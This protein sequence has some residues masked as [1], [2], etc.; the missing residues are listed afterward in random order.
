MKNKL[1][2]LVKYSL[3]KKI[4]S[5][6]FLFI[7]LF[8]MI[9][10]ASLLNIDTIISAFGG[11]FDEPTK[12]KVIDKTGYT[13]P[14]LEQS[15]NTML[16]YIPDG[17]KVSLD[18][19][20]VSEAEAKKEIK[21]NKQVLIVIQEDKENTVNA[22][23]ISYTSVDNILYQV[24][25]ASLNSAKASVAMA[26]SNIDPIELAKIN[27]GIDIK[28]EYIN[29]DKKVTDQNIDTIMAFVAP[30]I[31]LP[32]F[33]LLTYLVQMIGA[34]INE[35]KTTRGMEI[36]I[37]N[38]SPK[39]HLA[40]K[41]ISGNL[42]VFIQAVI[43]LSSIGIGFLIRRISGASIGI[44]IPGIDFGSIFDLMKESGLYDKLIYI[45]PVALIIIILT[46]VAYSLLAGI[47]ASMT[48]SIEDYQQLQ[49]PMMLILV[50]SYYL[51]MLSPTF[52]GATFIRVVSYIPFVSGLLT[53]VL[54]IVGQIGLLDIILSLVLLLGTIY[55]LTKYG[56]RIYKVGILNYSTSKLWTKMFKAAG[57]K[58]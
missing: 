37:S 47:L 58:I 52:E 19:I 5:K 26:K 46:F 34:E 17:I 13:Y 38:V 1:M 3:M 16:D 6:W 55:L 45:V 30:V 54:L 8:L 2:F 44:N 35:E 18:D 14:I 29:T 43:M 39:I 4:K 32:F 22:R 40:S 31:V 20:S 42:F 33:F 7:N 28:S 48:T 41:V 51:A 50:F 23:V 56:L 9:L 49:T 24:I 36:I 57:S 12:I 25:V 11:D 27:K 15:F 53:P 21:D 10:I